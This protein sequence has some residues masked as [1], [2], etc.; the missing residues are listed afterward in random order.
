M[1]HH[2]SAD[3][4]HSKL[5]AQ[6]NLLL[7]H[8]SAANRCHLQGATNVELHHAIQAVKPFV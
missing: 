6:L 7:R 8:V 1:A 4:V 2:I 5:T 3:K